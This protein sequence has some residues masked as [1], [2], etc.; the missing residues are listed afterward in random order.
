MYIHFLQTHWCCAVRGMKFVCMK[1]ASKNLMMR[2]DL[3]LNFPMTHYIYQEHKHTK[4]FIAGCTCTT[5]EQVI[6]MRSYSFNPSPKIKLKYIANI[7]SNESMSMPFIHN[8]LN[9]M[10]NTA[11]IAKIWCH[12]VINFKNSTF[13]KKKII[14]TLLYF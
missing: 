6:Q 12:R 4:L 1:T 11:S 2:T 8:T 9:K 7:P 3:Q 13:H 5:W 10:C 14:L